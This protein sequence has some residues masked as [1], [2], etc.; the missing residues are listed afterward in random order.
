[1]ESGDGAPYLVQ[2]LR[3]NDDLSKDLLPDQNES[4]KS[5]NQSI[6]ITDSFISNLPSQSNT[7]TPRG[8]HVSPRAPSPTMVD[9]GSLDF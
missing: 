5:N 6:A 2:L 4:S 7:L 1:M 8:R 9:D 3:E